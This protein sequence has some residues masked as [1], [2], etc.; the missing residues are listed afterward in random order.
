MIR[1]KLSK[2]KCPNCRRPLNKR[3]L[4]T[5]TIFAKACDTIRQLKV[6]NNLCTQLE[7]VKKFTMKT[8]EQI[9]A[10]I[11][12]KELTMISEDVEEQKYQSP[13]INRKRKYCE[14]S[15][16]T[17]SSE[18]D[19]R[20]SK[21]NST[22]PDPENNI[23]DPKYN[24]ENSKRPA[25]MILS[26]KKLEFQSKRRKE[27][28]IPRNRLMY[29]RNPRIT[30]KQTKLKRSKKPKNPP[31]TIENSQNPKNPFSVEN[32]VLANSGLSGSEKA[33]FECF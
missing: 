2:S 29:V 28:S 14:I 5:V 10:S 33:I 16:C 25:K 20:S 21:R 11:A 9:K 7:P 26:T 12:R 32:I 31:K 19:I 23:K 3:E 8:K 17:R 24:P 4:Q 6:D 1:S 30:S 27:T 18:R 13:K 15:S 22:K